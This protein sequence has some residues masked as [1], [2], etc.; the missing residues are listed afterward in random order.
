MRSTLMAAVVV[1]A[2]WAASAVRSEQPSFKPDAGLKA[3]PA[4]LAFAKDAKPKNEA[5]PETSYA[6]SSYPNVGTFYLEGKRGTC[7]YTWPVIKGKKVV[8][9]MYN[10]DLKFVGPGK[11]GHYRHYQHPSPGDQNWS[12]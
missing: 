10:A 11:S 1:A 12:F 3:A 8:D 5:G 4:P 7:H 6:V 2:A 9:L